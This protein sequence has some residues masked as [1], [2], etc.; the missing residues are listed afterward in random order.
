MQSHFGPDEGLVTRSS[1]RR[2]RC[3]AMHTHVAACAASGRGYCRRRIP[4][5]IVEHHELAQLLARVR[6]VLDSELLVQRFG[7]GRA[8]K[9]RW[10]ASRRWLGKLRTRLDVLFFTQH[11][12]ARRTTGSTPIRSLALVAIWPLT[13]GRRIGIWNVLAISSTVAYRWR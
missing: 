7:R 3:G 9:G 2:G 12:D 8:R 1:G 5:S 6:A 13:C 4:L 10:A 11:P